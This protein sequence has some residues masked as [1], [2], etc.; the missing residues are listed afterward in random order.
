[1]D[2]GELDM[3]NKPVFITGCARSGTSMIA[4]IINISGA[5]GGDM[6]PPNRNNKKGMFENIKVRNALVKP[7]LRSIKADPMGQEPLPDIE[8]CK[9][10][11]VRAVNN[12]RIRVLDIFMDQG[13]DNKSIWFYK[14]AKMCLFWPLWHRAFPKAKWIIVRRRTGDIVSSC[15]KTSFMRAY[16][17]PSGWYY[18]VDQ[19]KE[20]FLEMSQSG[21]DIY[22]VW[23]QKMIGNDFSEIEGAI[24]SL[25]LNWNKEKVI[26]FVEPALWSGKGV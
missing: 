16:K 15:M 14:G 22:H 18:W 10:V 5:F 2:E 17:K 8:S 23:P 21:L 1:M 13:Y 12:W 4:G 25:G 7:Y 24:K 19:H 9:L 20:R 11:S 26:D 3:I 6:S